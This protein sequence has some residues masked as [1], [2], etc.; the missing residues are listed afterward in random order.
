[1]SSEANWMRNTEQL[2]EFNIFVILQK[3]P[4]EYPVVLV[5]K[6]SSYKYDSCWGLPMIRIFE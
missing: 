4:V 1:M 6:K 5:L 2:R 3:L